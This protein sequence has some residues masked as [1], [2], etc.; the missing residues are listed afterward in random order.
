VDGRWEDADRPAVG[1]GVWV[2][3]GRA[4]PERA[5]VTGKIVSVGTSGF[6]SGVESVLVELGHGRVSTQLISKRG[7]DWDYVV[8]G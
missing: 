8:R 5:R 3:Y 4:G 1:R 7:I 6:L 2:F